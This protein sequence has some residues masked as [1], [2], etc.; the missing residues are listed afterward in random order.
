MK[1][2][3]AANAKMISNKGY[4]NVS[5]FS[6]KIVTKVGNVERV[7]T[8]EQLKQAYGKALNDYAKGL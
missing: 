5:E 6:G 4:R 2:I 1:S 3:I 7:K 8:R